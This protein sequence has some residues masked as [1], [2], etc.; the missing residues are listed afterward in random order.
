M[1]RRRVGLLAVVI[2]LII[3]ITNINTQ[4]EV[5]EQ[6]DQGSPE[7][8][9]VEPEPETP[10]ETPVPTGWRDFYLGFTP[11]PYDITQEA[12][13]NTYSLLD[14]HSDIVAHHFDSGVPWVAASSGKVYHDK[15][16]WDLHQ[17]VSYLTEESVVYLALTPLN[18]DRTEMAGNWD[19]EGN[20]PLPED[21]VGLRFNDSKVIDA[22]LNYCE[23][24][25]DRFDPDYVTYGIEVNMLAMTNPDVYEFFVSFVKQVY[26]SLKENHPDL[27]VFLTIQT[28]Y[29]LNNPGQVEAVD[30]LLPYTD[31]IALSSYPFSSKP[32]P[33][34]IPL[35][36]YS[37]IAAIAP[38]KPFCI[39]ET[40]FPSKTTS[41]PEVGIEI[42]GSTEHQTEFVEYLF[43]T[44]ESLDAE[45]IAWFVLAD[46][47]ATWDYLKDM[48]MNPI[49]KLWI[50]T[51]LIS[52][53]LD[54][55]PAMET[56]D[57][58]LEKERRID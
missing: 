4:S 10:E 51:G 53:E 17:R 3:V 21:W 9:P 39:A 43:E 28:E 24:M 1:D 30:Q 5:P 31:Y 13:K 29:Y 8:P 27:P 41:I 46:Y 25:I 19:A 12:V 23:D 33:S 45:F 32:D 36:Y 50:E 26:P 11:F 56:W 2:V 16:V 6:E 7:N 47:D 40:G 42:P 35:D 48:G 37:Q 49:Y 20:M 18:G 55:K 57:E 14:V 58:W 34:D 52:E 15:V 54:E 44:C 22:Y 38:E